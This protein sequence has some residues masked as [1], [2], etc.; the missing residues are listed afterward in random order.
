[1]KIIG[2]PLDLLGYNIYTGSYVRAADNARGYEVLPLPKEYPQMHMPWLNLLPESLYWGVRLISE[3]MG[4]TKLP[5]CITENGCATE[6]ELTAKGE[7]LDLARILYLRSYL[8]NAHRAIAEG[9]PLIGYFHWSLMDNFEWSW[10]YTRR[11]GLTYVDFKTQKR[12]PKQSFRWYQQTI[13]DNC[14]R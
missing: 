13:K 8:N 12:T 9:Y 6:D 4:K 14:V 3:A 2:Q 1:M 11:F 10:G 5:I 7:V